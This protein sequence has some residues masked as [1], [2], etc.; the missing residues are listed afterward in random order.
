MNIEELEKEIRQS[1]K[2]TSVPDCPIREK[3]DVEGFDSVNLLKRFPKGVRW[4]KISPEVIDNSC[5]SLPFFDEEALAHYLP[6][7]LIRALTNMEV[8]E[9]TFYTL[10]P[11]SGIDS[12]LRRLK[13]FLTDS[14][15]DCIRKFLMDAENRF[16]LK[17][18]EEM[19]LFWVRPSHTK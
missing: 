3:G 16:S 10:T 15:L 19:N 7:F 1:F 13:F 5:H 8:Y 14:Q 2:E 12:G 17:T 18:S 6:A 4:E 11:R 9:F